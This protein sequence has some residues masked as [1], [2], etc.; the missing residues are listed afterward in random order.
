MFGRPQ[1]TDRPAV[2]A[3][4]RL[5]FSLGSIMVITVVAAFLGVVL[6]QLY[7]SV[8]EPTPTHVA[9]FALAAALGPSAILIVAATAF[10]IIR[11]LKLQRPPT[12]VERGDD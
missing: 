10:K 8:V 6:N 3:P 9:Y 5:S 2:G 12:D 1:K 7:R 4:L 11:W